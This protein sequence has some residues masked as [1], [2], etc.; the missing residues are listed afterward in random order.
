MVMPVEEEEEEEEE[1]STIRIQDDA[2]T[3]TSVVDAHYTTEEESSTVELEISQKDQIDLV[4]QSYQRFQGVNARDL[5]ETRTKNQDSGQQV[6]LEVNST[7]DENDGQLS[8]DIRNKTAADIIASQEEEPSIW[9][10]AS[11]QTIVLTPSIAHLPLENQ[12]VTLTPGHLP[13]LDFDNKSQ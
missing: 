7:E 11:Y 1:Y 5:D 3:T 13:Q 6:E 4:E 12:E 8:M 10:S 9:P 2:Q